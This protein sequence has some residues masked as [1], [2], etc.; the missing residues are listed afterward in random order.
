MDDGN[1][2]PSGYIFNTSGFTLEDVKVLQA[3]LYDN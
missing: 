2:H 3:A 1:N